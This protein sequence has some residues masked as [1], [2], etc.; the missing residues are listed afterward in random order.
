MMALGSRSRRVVELIIMENVIIGLVGAVSGV[1]LGMVLALV[2]SAI[3]IPMP[4]P[5]NA[6]L[7]YIAHIRIV[8]AVVAS[9]FAV[10]FI[11][12]VTAAFLPALRVRRIPIVD[13]LR[14]SI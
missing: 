1:I 12:T 3:G 2:I 14:Q 5:P 11:A 8:P 7:N 9:A 13:A 6:D 10:G 4:P